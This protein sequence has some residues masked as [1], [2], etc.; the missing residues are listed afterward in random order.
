MR[1]LPTSEHLL[2]QYVSYLA[3]SKLSHGTTKCYWLQSDI[4][5]LQ[6]GPD[7]EVNKMARLEQ[8]LRG[9][10]ATQAKQQQIKKPCLPIS[11][12]LLSRLKESWQKKT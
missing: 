11:I 10:K 6:R 12:E 7:P 1:P 2:C 5:I 9:I 3:L 4:Y 8:V